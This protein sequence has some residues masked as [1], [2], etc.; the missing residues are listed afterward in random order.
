MLDPYLGQ[1]LLFG[2]NFAP[3]GHAFCNGQILP[4]AQNTALFSLLGT[5]YGGNGQNT[6]AL[7][8]LRGTVPIG[9]GQGSGLSNYDT[10]EVAGQESVTLLMTEMPAHGHVFDFSQ[11]KGTL[12]CHAGAGNQRDPSGHVP[13]TESSGATASYSDA[14]VPAATMNSSAVNVTG[15]NVGP[16]G[17]SQPHENRQPFLV[18]NYCIALFGVFPQRP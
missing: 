1:I 9:A 7:P 5:T 18:M 16:T 13:A 6:F 15:G 14:S 2:F 3:T 4:I 17:G 12:H 10:G 11:Y 8:N